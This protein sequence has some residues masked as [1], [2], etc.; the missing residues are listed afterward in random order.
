VTH[1]TGRW[2]RKG[3][4]ARERT[5]MLQVCACVAGSRS[6]VMLMLTAT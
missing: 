2:E 5:L 4:S 3:R 1:V 6:H